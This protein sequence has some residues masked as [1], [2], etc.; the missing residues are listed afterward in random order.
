MLAFL[1]AEVETSSEAD[2]SLRA[3]QQLCMGNLHVDDFFSSL[4]RTLQIVSLKGSCNSTNTI[5][6]SS[7]AR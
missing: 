3:E 7:S 2:V 6:S 4:R 1:H 5:Q